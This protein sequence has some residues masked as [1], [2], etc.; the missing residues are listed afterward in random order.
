MTDLPQHKA[1]L[2][3]LLTTQIVE[4]IKDNNSHYLPLVKLANEQDLLFPTL[5]WAYFTMGVSKSFSWGGDNVATNFHLFK[6]NPTQAGHFY[7]EVFDTQIDNVVSSFIS[8]P[9]G[10]SKDSVSMYLLNKLRNVI[11]SG[12]VLPQE[13]VDHKAITQY[14]NEQHIGQLKDLQREA[15]HGHLSHNIADKNDTAKKMKI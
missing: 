6:I 13:L 15:L 7:F 9:G 2:F 12:M 11:S 1:V 10:A 5:N 8:Q 14:M 4:G 3:N